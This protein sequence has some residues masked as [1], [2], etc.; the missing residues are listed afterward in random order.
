MEMLDV[1][2]EW[3]NPTGETV[4]RVRAHA[5]GY[6]HRTAHVWLIRNADTSPQILLQKRSDDK[7]S[8]PGCYDIS[9]AGHIPA[10]VE[11]LPSAVREL[12]EELGISVQAKQLLFC[13]QC[14][15][16]YE[17]EFYGERF[18][19]DQVSNVYL[20]LCPPD[21]TEDSFTLQK[22]EVSGVR[23][24]DFEECRQ[25][26]GSDAIRHCI[27]LNELEMIREKLRELNG[28]YTAHAASDAAPV[29]AACKGHC[30]FTLGCM[31]SSADLLHMLGRSTADR[32]HV[33]ALLKEQ[34][35]AIDR[36]ADRGGFFYYV[37]MRH[38]CFTFIGVD[39]M[40]ECAALSETGCMLPFE[41][42]PFGGRML[43]AMPD[44]QCVQHYTREEMKK[45]WLPYQQILRTIWE[46]Y[47]PKFSSDG[48]FEACEELYRQY[49]IKKRKRGGNS[50]F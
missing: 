4:E 17:R 40:G 46:E 43:E 21:W 7:D 39:A 18:I 22:E 38:K 47:E 11:F 1:V 49:Q 23:W 28:Y 42:R 24:M 25:A 13:G 20:L 35:L 33:L 2:D 15:D 34:P 48:T 36:F 6:R 19:D 26:V 3:G 45:D 10:G 14:Y 41:K 37:R 50:V 5:R 32:A 16:R 12:K 27:R 29:C 31:L 9:S 30:C 44:R 8:F